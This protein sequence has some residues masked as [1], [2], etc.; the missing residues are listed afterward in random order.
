MG[1][2]IITKL[3]ESVTDDDLL[4][5]GELRFSIG[6]D[7]IITNADI[8]KLTITSGVN[9]TISIIRGGYFTN[10]SFSSNLGT[11]LALTANTETS[12]YISNTESVISIPDKYSIKL[13]SVGTNPYETSWRVKLED[14]NNCNLLTTLR[15][16]HSVGIVGDLADLVGCQQLTGLYLNVSSNV[17]G[18]V[19]NL[20][21]MTNLKRVELAL[22]SVTGNVASLKD[23]SAILSLDATSTA[24]Y[25]DLSKLPQ[26]M[27]YFNVTNGNGAF[28]WSDTRSTN[29]Y[30]V[31][32][33][34]P[35]LGNDVDRMLIN[36][37][38][39]L[40]S[41]DVGTKSIS[42]RGTRTTTSDSA[43]QILQGKGYSVNV[44]A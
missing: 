28:L 19:G 27:V 37:S 11:S 7:P 2:C 17:T 39:C 12:V 5:L 43:V 6:Q 29:A 34:G 4:A 26:Q 30:V 35:N 16:R 23:S 31:T 42:V 24:V 14:F 32:L 25:G 21:R 20:A 10:S 15:L 13:F 44:T 33:I 40:V 36:Q 41:P 18:D 9:Q 38:Q 22:T 3:K 1:V 8:R